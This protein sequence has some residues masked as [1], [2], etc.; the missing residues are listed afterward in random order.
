ML[1]RLRKVFLQ[2]LYY[3]RGCFFNTEDCVKISGRQRLVGWI[4]SLD[5][6]RRYAA[7][8]Q[9]RFYDNAKL[10]E[11]I[12]NLSVV[13]SDGYRVCDVRAMHDIL[14]REVAALP[15]G[16]AAGGADIHDEIEGIV[17]EMS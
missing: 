15:N 5:I 12:R 14:R 1:E 4:K 17:A 11:L 10:V 9:L 6:H 13:Q 2:L 8:P 3:R 16:C 7:M